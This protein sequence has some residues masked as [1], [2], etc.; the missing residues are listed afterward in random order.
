MSKHLTYNINS[1]DTGRSVTG[2]FT[3][4]VR[5]YLN[6]CETEMLLVQLTNRQNTSNSVQEY[7][8]Q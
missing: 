5:T 4:K 7:H 3:V 8:A 6:R 2:M 1:I